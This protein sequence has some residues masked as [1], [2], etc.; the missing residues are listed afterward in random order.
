VRVPVIGLLGRTGERRPL[1]VA[2]DPS[3][4]GDEPWGGVVE[5]LEGPVQLDLTLEAV[6]DGILVRGGIAAVLRI[7]C[8]RCLAPTLHPRRVEVAEL[9]RRTRRGP[10]RGE[11]PASEEDDDAEEYRLVDGDTALEPDRMVR[12]AVLL[13]LPVRI[14][15]RPDCAGLC[16][17]CGA[18]RNAAPCAHATEP[19]ADPRWAALRPLRERLGGAAG[20]EG[21]ADAGRAGAR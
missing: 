10:V 5:A 3:E 13:D 14:L 17:T 6:S 16:P 1:V 2:V 9:H 11:E 15:C 4:L 19:P 21:P 7:P 12:D 8:A 18:D 20:S